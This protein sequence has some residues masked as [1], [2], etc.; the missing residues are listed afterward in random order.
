MYKVRDMTVFVQQG[1]A[2]E[3]AVLAILDFLLEFI[4]GYTFYSSE[5]RSYKHTLMV[6]NFLD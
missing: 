6:A 2:L 5:I 3:V 4:T 1:L